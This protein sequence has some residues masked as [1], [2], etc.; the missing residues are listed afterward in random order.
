MVSSW[1]PSISSYFYCAAGG[2][3]LSPQ[4][5][6]ILA[7]NSK[8]IF[9]TD[10]NIKLFP[11]QSH[12][13]PENKLRNVLWFVTIHGKFLNPQQWYYTSMSSKHHDESWCSDMTVSMAFIPSP[14]VSRLDC[15]F[16]FLDAMPDFFL[17]ISMLTNLYNIKFSANSTISTIE[18]NS[19]Q[20]LKV[21]YFHT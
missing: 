2:K 5:P 1:V 7:T 15:F 20:T 13:F 11:F 14:L 21:Y 8:N 17:I 9:S 19:S 12:L 4:L 6:V 16:S 10:V 3:V 18:F